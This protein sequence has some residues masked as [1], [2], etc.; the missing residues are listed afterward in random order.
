MVLFSEP[1]EG[2]ESVFRGESMKFESGVFRCLAVCGTLAVLFAGYYFFMPFVSI[3]MRAV[4]NNWDPVEDPFSLKQT[5]RDDFKENV[6]EWENSWEVEFQNSSSILQNVMMREDGALKC[7]KLLTMFRPRN[8]LEAD[9]RPF[10]LKVEGGA[11]LQFKRNA[12][13][14]IQQVLGN[15]NGLIQLKGAVPMRVPVLKKETDSKDPA[16]PLQAAVSQPS[17]ES[18]Q[19]AVP[20]PSAKPRQAAVPQ[21]SADPQNKK[22]ECLKDP[23]LLDLKTRDLQLGM[24]RCTTQHKV[25][26]TLG[27]TLLQM[28]GTGLVISLKPQEMLGISAFDR[29]E[30]QHLDRITLELTEAVLQNLV[31]F[32]KSDTF[33]NKLREILKNEKKISIVLTCQGPV[34]YEL[35]TGI[36]RFQ[37]NVRVSCPVKLPSVKD[38]KQE[39]QI[40]QNEIVCDELEFR[41]SDTLVKQLR[42]EKDELETFS[43]APASSLAETKPEADPSEPK[44]PALETAAPS[45]ANMAALAGMSAAVPGNVP[46]NVPENVPENVP[47]TLPSNV[48]GT[49]PEMKE[50]DGTESTEDSEDL[51]K[52]LHAKQIQKLVFETLDWALLGTV[53]KIDFHFETEK[54][55]L[56]NDSQFKLVNSRMDFSTSQLSYT[57]PSTEI[58]PLGHLSVVKPGYLT[59]KMDAEENS[60][61]NSGAET[62]SGSYSGTPSGTVSGTVSGTTSGTLAGSASG[63]ENGLDPSLM[64]HWGQK[65]ET[66]FDASRQITLVELSDNVLLHSPAWNG[67]SHQ[68]VAG[69]SKNAALRTD[70]IVLEIRKKSEVEKHREASLKEQLRDLPD[71]KSDA[72]SVKMGVD[73]VV[74]TGDYM[75]VRLEAA[76][77]ILLNIWHLDPQKEQSKDKRSLT[78]DFRMTG[79]LD[80]LNMDFQIPNRLPDHLFF[81]SEDPA[82][83]SEDR[84]QNNGGN[85]NAG[86]HR[87]AGNDSAEVKNSSE[88]VPRTFVLYGGSASGTLHLLPE[89]EGFVNYLKLNGKENQDVILRETD[90]KSA[91]EKRL[92]IQAHEVI[93]WYLHPQ[94]LF[95]MLRH[96]QNKPESVVLMEVGGSKVSTSEIH[97]DLAK[98]Q[99]SA[100]GKGFMIIPGS[101]GENED[102]PVQIM[103]EKSLAYRENG[104]LAD[105]NV[106]V[107]SPDFT[108]KTD[109][110]WGQLRKPIP[111]LQLANFKKMEK[112][113]YL[114]LFEYISAEELSGLSGSEGNVFLQ[115]QKKKVE[116]GKE[117]RNAFKLRTSNL[118]FVPNEKQLTADS[119]IIWGLFPNQ[120]E[121]E[122]AANGGNVYAA[123]VR[124]QNEGEKK[125]SSKKYHQILVRYHGEL[126][127]NIFD[128]MFEVSRKIESVRVET[129]AVEM[130]LNRIPE[131]KDLPENGILFEC[132]L[133]IVNQDPAK[134]MEKDFAWAKKENLQL[135]LQAVDNV[136]VRGISKDG[137][138]FTI[139]GSKLTYSQNRDVGTITGSP[140]QPVQIIQQI[141]PGAPRDVLSADRVD[142][143][144]KTKNLSLHKVRVESTYGN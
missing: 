107:L 77:S 84:R 46:G 113:E 1:G 30:L 109:R 7:D 87:N 12:E 67:Y 136:C 124:N 90:S 42:G 51:L 57:F 27:E 126:K 142:I 60:G 92:A 48:S 19:A 44:S 66:T 64:L 55:E 125:A 52:S 128:G 88:K 35:D 61:K 82:S 105:G 73:D 43:D 104:V 53:Q 75:P 98:N 39:E 103:W 70:R 96:D 72:E 86:N 76:G 116:N 34:S 40:Q 81:P 49:L 50:P 21:P 68:S 36:L 17:A 62:E 24:T 29:I 16:D 83:A 13:N 15:L 95:S 110:V 117:F 38:S 3:P 93:C 6:E 47:G 18:I 89:N 31:D 101:F 41:L 102:Q 63:Q 14:Q 71:R 33:R 121:D 74:Q 59:Y 134:L 108:M 69:N 37:K 138:I 80:S 140:K 144:W 137:R 4:K 91:A 78:P 5:L 56:S 8:A 119:G 123:D 9:S 11:I 139:H 99:L 79:M 45:L 120:Q 133:L 106:N 112:K 132:D 118:Y 10:C 54:I 131:F 111:L 94:T 28:S 58:G 2:S 65:L 23:V 97:L 20:Q 22:A 100:P 115:Y 129:D 32:G 85:G 25:F 143:Q 127:G 122:N 130:V 114:D 141:Y 135:E 26:L